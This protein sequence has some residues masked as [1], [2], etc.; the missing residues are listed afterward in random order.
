MH[1]A[2]TEGALG[3]STR[4]DGGGV[5]RC[6]FL[7]LTLGTFAAA[8]V[9][10][11]ACVSAPPLSAPGTPA[12]TPNAASPK[13][14]AA[15]L[16]L[17]TYV[18]FQGAVPD[19]PGTAA[20]IDPGYTT[21]P[22]N[23]VKSVTDTPGLGGDVNVMTRILVAIPPAVDQNPAWQAV[24]KQL[25]AT[26]KM[27]MVPNVEYPTKF[28]TTVAGGDLP[29]ILHIP[30]QLPFQGLPQ[31]LQSACA[32]LSPYLSGDAIKD[33]PNLANIPTIA[34]KQTIYGGGIYGV[35]IP[36]PFVQSIWYVNQDR[37]D[38][39]GSGPPKNADD[40]E[41]SSCSN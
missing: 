7:A 5:S 33:Y 16:Q 3:T 32:D 12:V 37:L 19:L 31:F 20:G 2:S 39:L 6:R 30:S 10:L 26:V 11:S 35:A 4:R 1:I 21:F 18:P 28:A 41:A 14:P 15:G 22:K 13:N 8:P 24:N 17:P 9:L 23:L 34:W 27:T 29:D 36:R 25:G 40:F 38:A